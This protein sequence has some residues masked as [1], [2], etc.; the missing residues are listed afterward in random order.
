[1]PDNECADCGATL[2][3]HE[4][5]MRVTAFDPAG[6]SND[7]TQDWYCPDCLPGEVTP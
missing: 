7:Y 2:L 6:D 1:M 3:V 5:W 4:A